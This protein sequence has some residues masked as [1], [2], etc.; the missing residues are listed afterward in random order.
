VQPFPNAGFKQEHILE[1]LTILAASTMTNYAATIA[2]IVLS[3][4][5]LIAGNSW[6][7]A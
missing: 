3:P 4:I 5:V 2:P 7:T 1:V 6:F